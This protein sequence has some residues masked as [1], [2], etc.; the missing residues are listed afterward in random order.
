MTDDELELHKAA[1][2]W[3]KENI[4]KLYED[5][6]KGKKFIDTETPA[7]SFMAGTPGAGKTEFSKRLIENFSVKPIRIDT[8]ELREKVPGYTGS[9]SQIIQGAASVALDKILDRILKNRL[10]FLLDTT[11]SIGR[12]IQNLKRADRRGYSLQ[13]YFVYQDPR[14][15]WEI[16]KSREIAEGRNVPRDAFLEAY[17]KSKENCD[18]AKREFGDKLELSLV[19]KNYKDQSE[20]IYYDIDKVDKYLPKIYTNSKELGGLIDD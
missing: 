5:L 18:T 9:N 15:A 1:I 7:A 16:T 11:F 20:H 3:V 2:L 6:V 17:F 8:D 19:I 10:P 4:D 14:Q 12:A 13:L